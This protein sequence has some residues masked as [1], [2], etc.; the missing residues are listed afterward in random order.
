MPPNAGPKGPLFDA[1]LTYHLSPRK[2]QC[3]PYVNPTHES[4]TRI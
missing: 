2:G 3:E 4:A 1:S